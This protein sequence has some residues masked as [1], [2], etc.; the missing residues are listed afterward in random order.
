MTIFSATL[1]CQY[2][3]YHGSSWSPRS[4]KIAVNIWGLLKVARGSNARTQYSLVTSQLQ[5][6]PSTPPVARYVF[7]S[8]IPMVHDR[9]Q[10]V[11]QLYLHWHIGHKEVW[12]YG[13][14]SKKSLVVLLSRM[15]AC[16]H[17]VIA[18]NCL[19]CPTALTASEGQGLCQCP[20]S[21]VTFR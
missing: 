3:R 19:H 13:V 6:N 4:G 2:V 1:L 16:V 10:N 7:I 14:Y 18:C 9:G 8:L 20:T 21:K 5:D 17:Q 12:N 11:F 15:T